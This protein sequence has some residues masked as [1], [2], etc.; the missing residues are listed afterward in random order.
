METI[1]GRYEREEPFDA[2]LQQIFGA[3]YM[4]ADNEPTVMVEEHNES[5][6]TEISWKP[7]RNAVL[8]L[9]LVIGI[10]AS[11]SMDLIAE[12]IAVPCMCVCAACFG[13]NARWK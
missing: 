9:A 8:F 1:K 13:W 4:D 11:Q 12:V 2:E 5:R 3:R 6:Q 10:G 7:V